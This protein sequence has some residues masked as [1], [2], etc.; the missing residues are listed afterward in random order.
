M[1]ISIGSG[2]A[3]EPTYSDE[4]EAQVERND[5][6]GGWDNGPEA[7]CDE[8]AEEMVDVAA[9]G[10]GLDQYPITPEQQAILDLIVGDAGLIWEAIGRLKD[11]Y[12]QK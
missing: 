2:L 3:S 9:W 10:R 7:I 12:A 4:V 1:R 8:M 5:G 11:T 6:A